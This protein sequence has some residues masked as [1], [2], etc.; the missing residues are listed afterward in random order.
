VVAAND[1]H[2]AKSGTTSA[3]ATSTIQFACSHSTTTITSL[4]ETILHNKVGQS[5]VDSIDNNEDVELALG[6]YGHRWTT[7]GIN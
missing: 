1:Q 5:Q 3:T 4:R 6:I 7:T 2:S